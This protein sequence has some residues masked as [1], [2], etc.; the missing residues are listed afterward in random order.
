MLVKVLIYP[1]S[2]VLKLSQLDLKSSLK[3]F[4]SHL[5][6]VISLSG[7]GFSPQSCNEMAHYRETTKR[8]Q[9]IRLSSSNP[10]AP[11]SVRCVWTFD[12]LWN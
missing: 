5:S 9:S 7:A 3:C 1:D 10:L 6:G 11:S 8:N 4:T 2:D 12:L